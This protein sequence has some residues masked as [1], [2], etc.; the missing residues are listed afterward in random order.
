MLTNTWSIAH[1]IHTLGMRTEE[2]LLCLK[3]SKEAHQGWP[4]PWESR[5]DEL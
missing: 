3:A 1:S 5:G 2:F 4:S